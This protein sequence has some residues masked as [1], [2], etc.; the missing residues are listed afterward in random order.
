MFNDHYGLTNAVLT[1]RKTQ[2]RRIIPKRTLDSIE[3]FQKDYYDDT[4]DVLE[5]KELM[6]Q[7]FFTDRAG[8]TKFK[9]G[10][11]VAVAQSYFDVLDY[12]RSLGSFDER[13]PS[14]K[15]LIFHNEMRIMEST[16]NDS[17]MKGDENKMFVRADL[18]PHQIRITNIRLE[19]LQDISDEDCLAEG[20]RRWEDEEEYS[21]SS[22]LRKSIK[23]LKA[24]GYEAFAIPGCWGCYTSPKEAY[25]ALIDKVSGKGTWDKNP[26]VFIYEFEL[27]K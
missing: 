18:M 26:W 22:S 4:L 15:E 9:V 24:A 20:I 7:Y 8:K 19:R 27:I 13:T 25:A 1:G 5:G 10:E 6:E 17:A 14:E 3:E 23:D 16:G 11:K 2:T 12:Y 21:T